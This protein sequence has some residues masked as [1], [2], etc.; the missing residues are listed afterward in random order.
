[1]SASALPD[2]LTPLP[3][4]EQQRALDSWAIEQLGISGEHLM[5]RAGRGLAEV[6]QERCPEGPMAIVCGKGNNGGDGLVAA[7]LLRE[8]GRDVRVLLLADPADLQGEARANLERLPGPAP[9]AFSPAGLGGAALIVD[10]IL[11]TGFSGEPRQPALSAIT[12]INEAGGGVVA[13]DVPSGVDASTGEVSGEA[14]KADATVTFHGL[15]PGLWIRPGKELAGAISV[16]DIGI[17]AQR[18]PVQPS[19]G[20]ITPRVL[21]A[22]PRR[23]TDS[24]KFSAG[25]VLVCGGSPGLTGAP[26]MASL[27]A[28]RAGAGYVTVAVPASLVSIVAAKLLEIMQVSLPERDG[29]LAPEATD[30]VLDRSQRVQA[31]V[32]GPGLGREDESLQ[33]ARQVARAVEVPLV[34]DADGLN[35]HSG[36]RLGAL[37]DRSAPAVL[38]PHAGE[39]G[40]L[41]EIDSQA[42]E[43]QRLRHARHAAAVSGSIVVLKGDDTLIVEPEG[44]V[45]VSAGGASA[46]AT[47]GTGD[48]LSGVL[49]AHLARGMEPFDAACAA[50]FVH[51]A[52]GRLA[53]RRIGPEGVI[54]SDVIQLLPAVLASPER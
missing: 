23:A 47:A 44:R 28:A 46:L 9:E 42:V 21:E 45:G 1:M 30:A 20:L 10:A 40:R 29:V 24:T 6:C 5:E 25:S 43:A 53:A 11:G 35:A 51:A 33:F 8:R 18:A 38:T 2:W 48:V 3:D 16:I 22:I 52:A 19:I 34:L 17:P 13:C 50:V 36:D 15:K 14:V 31:L 4:A 32:L 49:A 7:R 27:A 54:A 37:R 41:L 39:L 26:T 12:A